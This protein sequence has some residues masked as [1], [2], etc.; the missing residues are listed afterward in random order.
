MRDKLRNRRFNQ[1]FAIYFVN[2]S[3]ILMLLLINGYGL[4]FN[5]E[6]L[7]GQQNYNFKDSSSMKGIYLEIQNTN[8]IC[9]NE[10]DCEAIFK[11]FRGILNRIAHSTKHARVGFLEYSILPLNYNSI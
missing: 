1:L 5:K 3:L 4:A 8:S 7:S 2:I 10:L 6:V 9:V 11:H